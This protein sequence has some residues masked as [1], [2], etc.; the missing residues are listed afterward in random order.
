MEYVKGEP[1]FLKVADKLKSFL[2]LNKDLVVDILII[3][4]GING[5]NGII[6]AIRGVELVENILG[7]KPDK[8]KD[9]FSPLRKW[10]KNHQE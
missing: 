9:I 7:N 2:Y 3:G 10:M 6:N 1:Y 5:A 4:G 8:F